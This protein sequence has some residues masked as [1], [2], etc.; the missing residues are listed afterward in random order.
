MKSMK[1]VLK[2][3]ESMAKKNKNPQLMVSRQKVG[4]IF[5][6]LSPKTLANLHSKGEGPPVYKK[7]RIAFYKISELVEFLTADQE[8]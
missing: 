8:R 6:G 7:G 4:E 2:A 1:E 3:F 5:V